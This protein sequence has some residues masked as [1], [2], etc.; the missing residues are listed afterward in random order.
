MSGVLER[1][2]LI[3]MNE[4]EHT[5]SGSAG[6]GNGHEACPFRVKVGDRGAQTT[7]DEN[8]SPV[9]RRPLRAAGSCHACGPAGSARRFQRLEVV[10]S[11]RAIPW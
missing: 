5:Y 4:G 7:G 2:T 10:D 6:V 11:I 1:R 9:P 8:S 3:P